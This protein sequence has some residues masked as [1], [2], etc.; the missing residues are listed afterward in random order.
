MPVFSSHL[1]QR[2]GRFDR[3]SELSSSGT[4]AT[5]RE[6]YPIGH[7]H[8]DAWT[9]TLNDVF[10]AFTS[11]TSTLQYVLTDLEAEFFDAAVSETFAGAREVVLAQADTLETQ[12]RAIM[13][14]IFS[15][16]SRTGPTMK[17]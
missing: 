7:E 2:L 6:N 12:R 11:S 17:T 8:I 9:L 3:W 1:E 14:R 4:S 15:T 13:A 10:G 5:F 16:A